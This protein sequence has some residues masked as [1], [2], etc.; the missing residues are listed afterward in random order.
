MKLLTRFESA[1]MLRISVPTLDRHIANGLL[2]PARVGGRVFF[3][4]DALKAFLTKSEQNKARSQRRK[5][6]VA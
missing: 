6:G 5:D 2:I 3:R 4:E 1:K